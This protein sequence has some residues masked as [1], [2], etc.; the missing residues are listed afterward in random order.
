MRTLKD[1]LIL[2]KPRSGLCVSLPYPGGHG[3][4]RSR[5]FHK[6]TSTWSLDYRA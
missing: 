2:R 3:L 4:S 6:C 1:A 5:K